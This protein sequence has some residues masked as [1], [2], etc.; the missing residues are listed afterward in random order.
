MEGDKK[1]VKK[2]SGAPLFDDEIE[3]SKEKV[4]EKAE[5]LRK[6]GCMFMTCFFLSF[7]CALLNIHNKCRLSFCFSDGFNASADNNLF[8]TNVKQEPVSDDEGHSEDGYGYDGDNDPFYE[9]DTFVHS[10]YIF[11]LILIEY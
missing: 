6:Q 5:E 8:G 3:D 9:E 4:K 1:E 11:V 2:P 10:K 7:I